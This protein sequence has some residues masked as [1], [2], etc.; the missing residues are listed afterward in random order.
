MIK[1]IG[2]R[3][4][5]YMLIFS[6]IIV[7]VIGLCT[8]FVLPTYYLKK[9]MDYLGKSEEKI[10]EVYLNNDF[11]SI[12]KITE[13]MQNDLGGD[14]YEISAEGSL[15]GLRMLRGKNH[16]NNNQIEKF[17]PSGEISIYTYQNKIGIEIYVMGI[18]IEDYYLVYEVSIESLNRATDTILNFIILMLVVVF[19]IA[20]IISLILSNNI[21]KPIKELNKLAESMKTKKVKPYLVTKNKDEISQ[22]NNTL[23]E[24]YE[25]LLGN[26]Y[27]LN[28]ELNKEKKAEL[29]KKRFL[30]QATHELKTPIAVIRGYAEILYDGMYKNEEERDRYLKNIFDETASVSKLIVDVLEYTKMETGNYKIK[31][32]NILFKPFIDNLA[33]R[34]KDFINK[35]NL[36]FIYINKVDTNLIKKIDK[37]R[38]EQIYKNLISNAV[39]HGVSFVRVTIFQYENKI[40]L[41]VFNDGDNILEDDL[42]NVFES[43]YKKNGKKSGSGLGLA[44]VK[45]IVLLHGGEYRAEN[46]KE[47]VEFT[48]M[49]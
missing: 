40:C 18:L 21:S 17:V 24:L 44:I 45:Q 26:I 37:D 31:L 30:A 1:T 48:I 32:E 33:N 11:E 41:R 27:Q 8:K 34:Y 6:I 38:F 25:E 36:E 5:I 29:L 10:R 23:N 7:G 19:V 43:F 49:I 14:L 47:G 28:I 16:L 4:F 42:P 35:N 3:I 39:E 15:R 13:T 22:L 46:Q 9:Q 20:A 2:K 12:F